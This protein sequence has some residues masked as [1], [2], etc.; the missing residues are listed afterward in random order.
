MQI[1]TIHKINKA[2]TTVTSPAFFILLM[3]ATQVL[4]YFEDVEGYIILM[5]IVSGVVMGMCLLVI[6][7]SA[8]N[9]KD[10][11]AA[12]RDQ[13]EREYE[14]WTDRLTTDGVLD[15]TECDENDRPD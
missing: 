10:V 9:K 11:E 3:F 5:K 2:L 4:L 1:R 13:K 6:V 8:L 12:V 14:Y 7:I 15:N